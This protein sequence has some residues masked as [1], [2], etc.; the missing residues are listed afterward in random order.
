MS[1]LFGTVSENDLENINR[2]IKAMVNNQD[3]II[4]ALDVC[5]SVLKLTRIQ[6]VE[7]KRFIMD[8]SQ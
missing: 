7:N 6:V 5:L 1:M 4:H 3:Q 8:L 2:K